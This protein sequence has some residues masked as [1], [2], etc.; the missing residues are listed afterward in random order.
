MPLLR[1][2]PRFQ[3]QRLLGVQAVGSADGAV[4]QASAAESSIQATL[5]LFDS[6]A[7]C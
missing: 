2:S 4:E 3:L 1:S 5:D 7:C 6:F